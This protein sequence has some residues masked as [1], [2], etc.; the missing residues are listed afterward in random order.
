MQL[1]LDLDLNLLVA[2][3][4]L[5]EEGSVG[6]AAD[7]LNLSSP[8]MSR[9]LG[10][11]RRALGDPVL[12]RSGRA[13]VPT[14]RALAVR[15]EVHELVVR[16]RAVFAPAGEVDPA[17]L[18]RVFTVQADESLV[19]RLGAPLLT[20]MRAEAPGVSLRFLGEGPQDVQ[21]LREDLAD[22]EIGNIAGTGPETRIEPLLEERFMGVVRAGHPLLD[23]GVTLAGFAAADHLN[24]SRRGRFTGPI[25]TALAAH[26]L[27]RRVVAVYP[28]FASALLALL[29]TDFVGILGEH[30]HAAT[31]RRFG[32]AT[33]PIP[34]DLPPLRL[35]LAWHPR[36][37]ADPAH[38]WLR[39]LVTEVVRS[40]L[41][42]A[43]A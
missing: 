9:T 3:D 15:A 27:T 40:E 25:D 10:R 16:A 30:V 37:E 34:L 43:P 4:A 20:R 8:A 33:F 28:T 13:M 36:Y 35:S 6:G 1:N 38:T 2:L 24:H 21:F 31:A 42:P 5:L 23:G 26:G 7:R 29:D 17:R 11:I 14:P 32:L 19:V 12:V 41:G 39:G 18:E 22:L